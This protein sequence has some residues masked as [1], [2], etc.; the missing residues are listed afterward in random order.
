MLEAEFERTFSDGETRGP[1]K[2]RLKL[3]SASPSKMPEKEGEVGSRFGR[4][5][6]VIT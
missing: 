1:V 2:V 6:L 3:G 5:L 4:S